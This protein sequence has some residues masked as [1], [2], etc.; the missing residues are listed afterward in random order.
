MCYT[1]LQEIS[2]HDHD[3]EQNGKKA[4]KANKLRS[5]PLFQAVMKEIETQR[6]RGFVMHPKMDMLKLLI[7]QHFDHANQEDCGKGTRVMVF[8]E[9]RECV[10]EIVEALNLERPLIQASRFIGQGTDKQGN[11]GFGQ[12]EQLEVCS[13]HLFSQGHHPIFYL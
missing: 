8:V 12:R 13:L 11:R 4:A 1:Y 7:L 5:N 9:Y 10:D 6:N 3:H 2:S